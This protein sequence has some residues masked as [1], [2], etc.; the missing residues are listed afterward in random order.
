MEAP[1]HGLLTAYATCYVILI[2][3]F[4]VFICLFIYLFIFVGGEKIRDSMDRGQ[5]FFTLL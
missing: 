5:C 1:G 4:L 2:S 3:S